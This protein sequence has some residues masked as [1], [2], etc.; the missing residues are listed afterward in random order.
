M[1]SKIQYVSTMKIVDHENFG[2]N[3]RRTVRNSGLFLL[4]AGKKTNNLFF[5]GRC[6]GE[7]R[8][9]LKIKFTQNSNGSVSVKEYAKLFEGSS[10]NTSDLDGTASKSAVIAANQTK[11]VSFRVRNTD[12]G[13]DYADITLLITNTVLADGDCTN[14][15]KAKAQT[16]G[17]GFTGAATSNIN[18]PTTVKGGKR[19]TFQKCDIYC[20]PKTGPQEIHGAIRLKY[21]N[22]GGP[23]NALAL[24][25]T[26]ETTTP[27]TK[28]R[29]NHFSGNGSIYWHPTT[30]PK[31]VRGA[32]RHE[33]AKTGWERGIYGY[34]TSDEIK[35]DPNK[36]TWF[37]DFQNGVIIW[38]N[39][40]EENP[41][42]AKLSGRK[43]RSLFETIFKE[44]TKGQKDLNVDS[45]RISSVGNTGYDFT[46]S[47]NRKVTF[48][49][50]GD[51]ESGIFFI[52]NPS[53]TITLR[54]AFESN[55]N[56]D[57]K[58]ACKLTAK[59]DH[60]HIHTSGA[61]N[62]KLLA[63]LK[64]GI[65]EGFK[66]ALEL[67]DVPKNTGFLSF[68]VMKDGGIKLYFRGDILGKVVAGVAQDKLDKL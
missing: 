14:G 51:Y 16:L 1:Q 40:A 29:F 8:I 61:G 55:K 64:K 62:S 2:S 15:I 18:A 5:I 21:N 19:V 27:D 36:N 30:G 20:S 54:I 43:V 9:E 39:N 22:V 33:W 41:N 56:P 68:K 66:D 52:P 47:K 58:V 37:S 34:P 38:N 53:Y 28:G 42:T 50:K 44:K 59:L 23:N 25:V 11:T 3:E 12:E 4:D 26:D 60:W 32:I 10:T 67:G 13:D 35:I 46:R 6:G 45:V 48:K 49:I 57:G 31:L 7:V 24:P 63:G 65:L 17:T